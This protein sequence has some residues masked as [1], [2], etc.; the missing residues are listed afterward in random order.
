MREFLY[1]ILIYPLY[2]I[3]EFFY[4]VF[5]HIFENPGICL[6]CVSLFVS[7]ICLPLYAVA[8][9]WQQVERDTEKKLDGGVKRIKSV[10]K[11]DEQYMILSTYYRENHYQPIYAL[12]SSIGLLIQIPFFIAAYLFL[13]HLELLS[14][15]SFLFIKDLAHPDSL[16]KIGNFSVNI[17]PIL[18]TVI[19]CIA[20]AIYTKGFKL[21]EKIQIYAMAIVFLILLYDSPS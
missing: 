15:T 19:N 4:M 8:E 3:I 10:F 12:R 7:T 6:I 16:F 5:Y 11:G 21:K 18:M 20:G 9:H 13:S 2:L 17:L 14:N 1:T